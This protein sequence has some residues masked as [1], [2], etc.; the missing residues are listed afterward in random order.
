MYD[1]HYV[2]STKIVL[3]NIEPHKEKNFWPHN[4]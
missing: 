3:E 4:T 1:S 2:E